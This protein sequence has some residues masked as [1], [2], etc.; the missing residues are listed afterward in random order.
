M[1]A[2]FLGGLFALI[3]AAAVCG[4]VDYSFVLPRNDILIA[5]ALGVFQ[6]GMGLV[7]FTIGSRV[8]P[9]GELVLLTMTEVLLG[10]L[11]VWIFVG[12]SASFYTLAGGAI[13]LLAIAGNALSGLR[14][15]PV[16]VL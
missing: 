3:T 11:W 10:P 7:I 12:E 2:V 6:V 4:V 16:P 8:V 9:A 1:P 14:N 13:L 5:L 15:K